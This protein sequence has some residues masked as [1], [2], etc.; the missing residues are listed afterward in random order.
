MFQAFSFAFATYLCL[1]PLT[2]VFL[3]GVEAQTC[4]NDKTPADMLGPFY[5]A[6]SEKS[7]RIGPEDALS[8]PSKRL[9]VSGTVRNS[10]CNKGLAGI[11]MEVWFA[12]PEDGSGNFYQDNEYRGQLTT[13]ANG[14]FSFVQT[15]PELYSVRP[16]LHDHIRLSYKGNR[17]LVTQMYFIGSG[18]GF[19]SAD[20]YP[21]Q[22][23]EVKNEKD[24]SRSVQFDMY[25]N[26]DG[27]LKSNK[28]CTKKSDCCS[29]KCRLNKCR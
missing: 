14:N 23:V 8:D 15:F 4:P 2:T 12:G 20:D 18:N 26:F 10:N 13:D 29:N 7:T 21:M 1:V 27:C 28:K 16:I 5:V 6:R 9:T 25:L 24:G 19:V 22:A 17:L 11:T 3:Q